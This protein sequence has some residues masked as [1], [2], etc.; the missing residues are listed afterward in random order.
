[1]EARLESDRVNRWL[2]LGANLG[3][4]IGLILLIVEIEQNSELVRAEIEQT[5]SEAYVAWLRQ[6]AA[7]DQI[8]DLFVTMETLEGSFGDRFAQLEPIESVCGSGRY[9]KQ[10]STI[11][12]TYSASMK[13]GLLAKVTGSSV[14]RQVSRNGH[15]VGMSPI[16]P[17]GLVDARILKKKFAESYESLSNGCFWPKAEVENSGF[18]A[19]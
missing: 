19:I 17:T 18:R 14:P 11:T 8:L 13:T 16:L 15:H 6:A 9:L 5:R 2:T 3:V 1:M 12:R 10:D 7:N 4:L